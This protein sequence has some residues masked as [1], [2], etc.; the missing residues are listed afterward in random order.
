MTTARDPLDGPFMTARQLTDY[1][2][3]PGYAV[4][5]PDA[6][7]GAPETPEAA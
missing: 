3:D 6:P 2:G 7:A 5:L 4:R 1:S